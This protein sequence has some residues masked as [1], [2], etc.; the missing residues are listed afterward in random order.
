MLIFYTDKNK[1][2]AVVFGIS[3]IKREAAVLSKKENYSF[4]TQY[5][6]IVGRYIENGVVFLVYISRSSVVSESLKASINIYP[7]IDLNR[8]KVQKAADSVHG[9]AVSG[10][11]TTSGTMVLL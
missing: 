11:T 7:F 9:V 8:P 10:I 1:I 5:S 3:D 2:S 6:D 4:F